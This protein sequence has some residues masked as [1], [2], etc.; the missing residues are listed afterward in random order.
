MGIKGKT[1][2]VTGGNGFIGSHLIQNLLNYQAN[3]VVASDILNANSYFI[4][5]NLHKQVTFEPIDISVKKEVDKLGELYN[6]DFI[7]H[8][9]AQ[10]IV[11]EAY[12]NPY[13]TFK[14]NIMGTVNVLELARNTGV[15]G[16]VVASSD[17][18]Y[19]K[20]TSEYIETT[21]LRGDHPYDV[22]KSATDLITQTY[23]NTYKLPAVITRVG[24]V[25]GP[26][27][28]HYDRIIPGICN[29]IKTDTE[30][31][32]R[33]D[34]TYVR[35]YISVK[36]VALAY[37]FLLKN[38]EKI[39][40][41]AFN[42]SSNE[43]YSVLDLINL[44]RSNFSLEIRYKIENTA[45]NEIPYQHLNSEKINKLGWKNTTNMKDYFLETLE[46]YKSFE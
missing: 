33:S 29:S 2:L 18:A 10:T 34:G 26:G 20:T 37:V 9:A 38:F 8:L 36:D 46:W 13:N 40:G 31:K 15:K 32:I 22:S 4:K 35:D 7:F 45:K 5:K 1:I 19:G 30:L 23:F 27:D 21:A 6:F 3:I 17:K 11:T 16:I 24:N 42:I 41:E 14:I 12:T 28:L 43:T 39:K 25:Y 44:I